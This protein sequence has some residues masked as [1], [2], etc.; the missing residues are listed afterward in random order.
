VTD[1][2]GYKQKHNA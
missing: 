1:I 2:K